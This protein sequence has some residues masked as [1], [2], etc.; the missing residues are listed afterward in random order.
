VSRPILVAIL[1][2]TGS[3]KTAFGIEL[4]Q[5]IG[6]E[7]INLD[8]TTV[9]QQFNIGSAKPTPDEFRSVPHHLFDVL[10]PE[11]SFSAGDFVKL[12]QETIEAVI[13]RG[14]QPILVGGTYFYLRALQHGMFE[15]DPISQET[16]EA[17][18]K[19]FFDDQDET[20]DTR[21]LCNELRKVDPDSAAQIHA[22]DRY[23]LIRSL[24][25]FRTTGKPSSGLKPKPPSQT[26]SSIVWMK[27]AMTLSRQ[28]L[29]QLVMNRTDKML[30]QGLVTETQGILERHPNARA[31]GSIGYKEAVDHLLG[32]ITEKQLRQAII[33][34]TR[35]LIKRQWTWLRS[36]P[37]VRFIDSRDL[38]RV[39]LEYQNLKG[40]LPCNP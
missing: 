13:Q 34:K 4:A 22:N 35:Q 7:I 3:G 33:E 11:D 20:I 12:A 38:G 40:A 24:A 18:E 2:P 26:L 30:H 1:G 8:S 32:R 9:Y 21:A 29:H 15:V 28:A 37:E 16:I 36:D 31:L 5:K 23:R 39:S 27:Y 17:I 19:E 6:G 10:S 25:I 14:K